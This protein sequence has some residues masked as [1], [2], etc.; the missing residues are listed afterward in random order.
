MTKLCGSLTLEPS[1][2][3]IRPAITISYVTDEGT[4]I[5]YLWIE[6]WQTLPDELKSAATTLIYGDAILDLPTE[7]A[8]IYSLII[9]VKLSPRIKIQLYENDAVVV[10][11]SRR[12]KVGL[13]TTLATWGLEKIYPEAKSGKIEM[14]ALMKE[15]VEILVEFLKQRL[16]RK[17]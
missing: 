4:K 1:S 10:I 6:E 2:F 9:D 7:Y 5:D 16:G 11:Y 8:I 17:K 15:K 13:E 12:P 14:P 3:G